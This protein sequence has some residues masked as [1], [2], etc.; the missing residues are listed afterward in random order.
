MVT[1][2]PII[3]TMAI[4]FVEKKIARIINMV[5]LHIRR[6]SG[7][8]SVHG[9]LET[10]RFGGNLNATSRRSKTNWGS[11]ETTPIIAI[12]PGVRP[13]PQA[14]VA[15]HRQLVPP[16]A[17]SL[18][19]RLLHTGGGS[20]ATLRNSPHTQVQYPT[21]LISFLKGVALVIFSVLL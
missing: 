12:K 10:P 19:R 14:G 9:C 13:L 1:Y 4:P 6:T 16:T 17:A 11:A 3:T 18:P 20:K 2:S 15:P 21:G 7:T 8:G 5:V